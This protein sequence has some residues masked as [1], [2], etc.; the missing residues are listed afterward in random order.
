MIASRWI[1]RMPPTFLRVVSSREHQLLFFTKC[2][3]ERGKRARNPSLEPVT[4]LIYLSPCVDST[5]RDWVSWNSHRDFEIRINHQRNQHEMLF[6]SEFRI[7]CSS[8]DSWLRS[9]HWSDSLWLLVMHFLD[10]IFMYF[11]CSATN[12]THQFETFMIH[13]WV[14]TS[15]EWGLRWFIWGRKFIEIIMDVI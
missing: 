3:H 7:C 6:N 14:Q 5:S 8:H 1:Q 4:E 12:L 11:W 13:V 10:D 15:E 2:V 9:A